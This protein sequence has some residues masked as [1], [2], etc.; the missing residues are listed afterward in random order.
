MGGE[1]FDKIHEFGYFD[2]KLAALIMHQVFLA[3]HHCHSMGIV[4]RDLKP[5]NILLEF[6]SSKN[7]SRN[8]FI[9]LIDFGTSKPFT[10]N[11]NLTEKT[12]TV[13]LYLHSHTM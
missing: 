13:R 9:K 3:V 11:Q 8:F 12:G 2:E 7:N 1:L 4:H 6:T 5:E 10:H